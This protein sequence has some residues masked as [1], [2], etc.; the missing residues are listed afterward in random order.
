MQKNLALR[1]PNVF[2]PP[3]VYLSPELMEKKDGVSEAKRK[4]NSVRDAT[5]KVQRRRRPYV[6]YFLFSYMLYDFVGNRNW[7]RKF[8]NGDIGE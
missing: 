5:I 8:D 6:T 3:T 1:F 7:F 2:A 4:K